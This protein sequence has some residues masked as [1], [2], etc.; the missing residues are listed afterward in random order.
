MDI[1]NYN[2]KD[3]KIKS[4]WEDIQ[5]LIALE[6]QIMTKLDNLEKSIQDLIIRVT[7]LEQESS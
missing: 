2:K 5:Q 4:N 6:E 7:T 1:R 3:H